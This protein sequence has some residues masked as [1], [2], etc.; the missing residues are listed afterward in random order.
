MDA[1]LFKGRPKLHSRVSFSEADDLFELLP[2]RPAVSKRPLPAGHR[3]CRKLEME[4][5]CTNLAAHCYQQ[6]ES[7]L[8]WKESF[9]L[10][11]TLLHIIVEGEINV[12]KLQL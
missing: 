6:N 10:R 5:T 8:R 9:P 11:V 12:H 7:A 3:H 4:G 1:I 2:E